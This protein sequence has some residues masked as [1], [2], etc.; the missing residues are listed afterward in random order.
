MDSASWA[1]TVAAGEQAPTLLM[2]VVGRPPE[3]QSTPADGT[4]RAARER[5]LRSPGT[6]R[7]VL[8][9]MSAEE[10]DALVRQRL[11]VQTLPEPVRALVMAKAEGRPLFVEEVA[12]ALRDAGLVRTR[13]GVARVVADAPELDNLRFPDTVQGLITSRIDRLPPHHELTSR[14]PA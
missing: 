13:N 4:S 8:T 6:R 12:A 10:A 7:L 14:W 3:S 2:V 9:A 1:L 5:L 11:G